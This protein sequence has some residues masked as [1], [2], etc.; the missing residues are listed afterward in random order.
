MDT[1][2]K[3]LYDVMPATIQNLAVTGYSIILDKKRYGGEFREVKH[4]LEESQWYTEKQLIEYQEKKLQ[5][6]IQYCY[7]HVDYYR[8]LMEKLKLRPSDIKTIGDLQKLPVLTKEIIKKNFQSLLSDEYSLETVEKGHT[9]GTTGSPLEI[10]YSKNLINYNYAMLDRQ[11][12]WARVNLQRFGD[13][14]AVIRG[15]IIVPLNTKKPPFWRYNYYHNQLLFSSF[16]LKPDN[17]AH[18]LEE[19]RRYSPKTLDGYPST[20]YILAKYLKNIGKKIKLESVLTSSETLY[21]F[22]R[23]TI[24]ESFDCK[25]Y[26]YYGSAERVLF[27]TECDYH[28]GGHIG[29]E[30]GIT[31]ICDSNGNSIER[32]ATGTV[33][34]TSLHNYAMPLIRYK[35]NDMSAIKEQKCACGR[36]HY[37]LNEVTTKAEDTLVLKD[38]RLISPSVLTHP[39]KPLTSILESQIIQTDLTNIT[40]K[41]RID[42][43]FTD[44]DKS[45]L[46]HG[47][48]E[49]L[50]SDTTI[51]IQIVDE[52]ERTP[53]GKFKWVISN[54]DM[55][56]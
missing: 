27:T 43:D 46:I 54:I 22:Q 49:R 36:A 28:S 30:Y 47:L 50:G 32:G 29:M 3:N 20:V 41:L 33:V 21:D 42:S 9:S 24:E 18:Y 38:G 13:K 7:E 2:F 8:N 52:L 34:A 45:A 53:T 55:N 16:H 56:I 10:C 25:V 15:N 1:P 17:I 40:I 51:T 5:R 31:E 26:D 23:E 19:L 11:Y 6:L 35:T 14:V 44:Y 12:S 48:S 39:F 37:L 4:F